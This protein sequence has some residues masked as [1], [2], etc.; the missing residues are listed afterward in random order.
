M[1]TGCVGGVGAL[2]I[3][4]NIYN[5]FIDSSATLVRGAA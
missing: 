5:G 1:E 4:L 2:A 3:Y